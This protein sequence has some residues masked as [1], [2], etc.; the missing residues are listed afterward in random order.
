MKKLLF[1]GCAVMFSAAV[2]AQAGPTAVCDAQ[3][4][5]AAVVGG[6]TSG[7]YFVRT[8]FNPTCSPN[9]HMTYEQTSAELWAAAASTKGGNVFG[10][11]TNGGSTKSL[12][13]CNG[14]KTCGSNTTT[15][16][17]ANMTAAKNV[18]FTN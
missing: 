16:V 2:M 17:T 13:A 18:G 15:A 4:K 9:T 11:S 5:P 3:G 6:D 8:P 7:T 10:G 12:A 14:G 1:V